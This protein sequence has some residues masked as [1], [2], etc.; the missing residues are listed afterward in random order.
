MESQS[1]LTTKYANSSSKLGIQPKKPELKSAEKEIFDKSRY[2][3][4]KT[5]HNKVSADFIEQ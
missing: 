1:L 4:N 2:V 3:E 5:K